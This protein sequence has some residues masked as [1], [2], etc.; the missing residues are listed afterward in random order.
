[1]NRQGFGIAD[2]GEVAEELELVDEL[3]ASC[4]T[5][6]DP[7]TYKCA[8]FICIKILLCRCVVYVAFKARV[9]D[10]SH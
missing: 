3:T 5:A 1:M 2:I 7:E 4:K 9:V 8:V 6:F 10:P